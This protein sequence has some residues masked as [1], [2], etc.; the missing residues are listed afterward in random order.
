MLKLAALG[1]FLAVFAA[2][3]DTAE[4][5]TFFIEDGTGV[6]G[7][8][9]YDRDLAKMALEAWARE[10]AGKLRFSEAKTRDEALLRVRWVPPNG[11]FGEMERIIVKGKPASTSL[12][13]PSV[14]H[15]R[16]IFRTSCITSGSAA[17]SSAS[18]CATGASSSL[19][20]T[21]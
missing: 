16:E 20:P 18:S 2:Q 8:R 15:T 9:D 10:S 6:P 11:L 5:V 7:Y 3:L 4:P 21:S 12:A 19:A 13:T 17:T 1:A 14:C